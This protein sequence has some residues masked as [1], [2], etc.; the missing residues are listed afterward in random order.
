M[1]RILQNLLLIG[2]IITLQQSL[3]AQTKFLQCVGAL[4]SVYSENLKESRRFFVQYPASYRVTSNKKYP[5]AFVL[6]GHGLLPVVNLVQGFYSGGF[7]PEM[8]LIGISNSEH[9]TRDLTTSKVETMYGM[10]YKQEHGEAAQ[11]T[12]FLKSELIPFVEE[13][14]PVTSFRTLIGHSYGGLFTMHTLVHHPELFSNY[15]AIDPSLDWDGEQLLKEAQVK[16][17]AHN[18]KGKSLF[19]SLNGQLH[20]QN[21]AV[22]IENVMEDTSEFTMFPRANINF[23]KLLKEQASGLQVAWKFYPRDLH[24][25]IPFPSIMDGLIFDFKWFQMERT[26]KFNDPNTPKEELRAIITH[27]ENKLQDYFKYPVTPYPEDLFNALGYMSMDME[28]MDKAEMFFKFAIKFYPTSSNTY[29]SMAD[30]YEK[31]NKPKEAFKMVSKA[32]ELSGKVYYKKRM[33]AL[34]NK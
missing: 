21:P 30:F 27:R 6:D 1:T 19:M 11:F 4:D 9:R 15:I 31:N 32:Y 28:Q 2:I 5:V 20:N 25:T 14:Y 7:M 24:G 26:D 16:L 13:K 3:I 8:I 33:E 17:K 23:S 18:Y 29:D 12:E 22:T 34:K 10:P